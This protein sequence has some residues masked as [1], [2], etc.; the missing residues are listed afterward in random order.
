M[1]IGLVL[2]SIILV[3]SIYVYAAKPASYKQDN[4]YAK[5][6]KTNRNKGMTQQNIH[7]YQ[8]SKKWRKLYGVGI[9]QYQDAVTLEELDE[10]KLSELEEI[11]DGLTAEEK[12]D[13]K[14]FWIVW[15][16]GYAWSLDDIPAPQDES[17]EESTH[18]NMMTLVRP[19]FDTGEGILFEVKRGVIGHDGERYPVN[20]FG[21]LRKGDDVFHMKLL[22]TEDEITLMIIGKVFRGP[23]TSTARRHRWFHPV[24]M[25]G[26]L[27]VDGLEYVIAMRGRA[28]R[29]C[30]PRINAK[31][32]PEETM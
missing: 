32:E 19:V 22:G 23:S 3:S 20:G 17:F 21:W 26:R 25:V 7:N 28:F 9:P 18:I 10:P 31:N 27:N 12:L 30:F 4:R 6:I 16:K 15:A 8:N 2:I 29:M 5:N 13:S 14:C 24:V 1:I 11:Y